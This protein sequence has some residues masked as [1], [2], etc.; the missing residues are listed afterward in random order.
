[1]NWLR[2][3]PPAAAALLLLGGS[4]RVATAGAESGGWALL[5]LGAVCTGAW[6]VL[7]TQD[8]DK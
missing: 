4:W 1:M 6:L 3:A 7:H 5:I 2:L 8:R